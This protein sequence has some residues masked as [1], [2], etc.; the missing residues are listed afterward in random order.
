MF[1]NSHYKS[2]RKW[3]IPFIDDYVITGFSVRYMTRSK[4]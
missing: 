4:I 1:I 3:I 2:W